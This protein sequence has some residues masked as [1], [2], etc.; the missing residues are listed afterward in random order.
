MIILNR[1]RGII[2]LT[3]IT[4]SVMACGTKDFKLKNNSKEVVALPVSNKTVIIDARAWR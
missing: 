1:K 4:I 3:L 2:L